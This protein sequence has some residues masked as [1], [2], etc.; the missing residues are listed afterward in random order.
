MDH[1]DV[2]NPKYLRDVGYMAG[3]S[4]AVAV[5]GWHN[6]VLLCLLLSSY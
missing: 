1:S 5:K 2:C 3:D 6:G 4:E